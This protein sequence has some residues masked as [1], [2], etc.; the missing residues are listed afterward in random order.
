VLCI[1]GEG[2]KDTIC[3]SLPAAEAS[4]VRI[5]SGHHFDGDYSLMADQ[6][7]AFAQS[8][9]KR[10]NKGPNNNARPPG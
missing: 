6:I 2:E 7:L 5:G 10:L 8:S 4:S 1:Y 9:H 3:P